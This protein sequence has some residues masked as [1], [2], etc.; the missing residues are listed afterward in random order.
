MTSDST[1]SR[2]MPVD[3]RNLL[4]ILRRGSAEAFSINVVGVG[5]MFLMHSILGRLIGPEQYGI[6]SHALSIAMVLS[7]VAPLGWHTALMRF[8]AQYVV[9][10]KPGLVWGS[11]LRGHQIT[12]VSCCFASVFLWVLG[13]SGYF[14]PK[15][16]RSFLSA[17][18][19]LLPLIQ[20]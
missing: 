5:L 12:F 8:V 10:G 19:L 7:I 1:E 11:I 4:S 16:A 6:F 9:Q 20:F 2:P 14:S 17:G 15:I 18:L 13:C 3:N